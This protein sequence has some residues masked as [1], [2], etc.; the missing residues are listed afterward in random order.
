[1]VSIPVSVRELQH[2][3]KSLINW[4][5]FGSYL[6]RIYEENSDTIKRETLSTVEA[7]QKEALF[8]KWLRKNPYSATW[9]NVI[10]ALNLSGETDL[11]QKLSTELFS[12][13]KTT[14]KFVF[15]VSSQ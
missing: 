8:R 9:E 5:R 13:Q 4:E 12:P 1:M 11:A 2:R 7:A 10:K 3:L 15:S 6:P 14:G